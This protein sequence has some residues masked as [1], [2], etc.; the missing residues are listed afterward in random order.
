MGPPG[1]P[2]PK[3][4]LTQWLG[5]GVECCF[6]LLFWLIKWIFLS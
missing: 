2:G 6:V 5:I 1:P 4:M 3:G